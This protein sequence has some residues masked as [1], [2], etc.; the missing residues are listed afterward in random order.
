MSQ[1]NDGA[2]C[3]C[4]SEPLIIAERV[5]PSMLTAQTQQA[6]G[7][8]VGR[9]EPDATTVA[10]PGGPQLRWYGGRWVQVGSF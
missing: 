3:I 2:V 1:V 4:T 8:R 7:L 10:P 9:A 5:Q 6:R